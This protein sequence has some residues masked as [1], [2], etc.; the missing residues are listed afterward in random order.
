MEDKKLKI[1]VCCG[2]KGQFRA[3]I[4][5]IEGLFSKK[6]S[7]DYVFCIGDFFGDDD[8]DSNKEWEQF[9]NTNKIVSVPV[10]ILGPNKKQHEKYYHNLK[11]QQLAP[12]IY[13]LG[14]HGVFTTTDGLKIGY[15][16]GIQSSSKSNNEEFMF[17][18]DSLVQFKDS[19]HRSGHVPLDILLTSPWPTDICNKERVEGSIKD[20]LLDKNLEA[21]LLSWIADNLT[22]RYHFAGMQGFFYQRSPYKNHNSN[23]ITR[24]VGIGDYYKNK[25]SKQKWLYGFVISPGSIQ[26][27]MDYTVTDS[28]Y[29]T[30]TSQYTIGSAPNIKQYFYNTEL[31][32]NSNNFVPHK[33]RKYDGPTSHKALDIDA[34]SCWFCLSS[35]NVS[36]HMI[37]SIGNSVYIAAAK[38]PLVENHILLI[39]IEHIKSLA[40]VPSATETE[41]NLLKS[42]INQYFESINQAVVYFERSIMS[43]HF[44]LQVVPVSIGVVD[45]LESAFKNKFEDHNLNLVELPPAASLQQ[46]AKKS[47][48]QYFYLELPNGKRFYHCAAKKTD[49]RFPIQI[50]REV[51]ASSKILNVK[52]RIDWKKCEQTENEEANGVIKFRNSF[53][54]F[55]P[56]K[57]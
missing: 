37:I 1:L 17:N 7:F 43:A 48:G 13:Y 51:L 53:A 32:K 29:I 39:P 16:S 26:H 46:I 5:H 8:S 47:N 6:G 31:N 35:K 45:R 9:I 12:N 27:K 10:Y 52:D 40:N 25:H 49:Q 19:C 3:F 24:F 30:D 4:N 36:K 56:I 11:N 20:N 18:Y 22:P 23:V 42:S 33:K 28:P 15:V 41:I 2:V 38:G 55:N 50:A 34:Q 21:P 54:Q 14:K 57:D 44:Q